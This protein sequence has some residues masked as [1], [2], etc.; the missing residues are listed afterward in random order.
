[1]R[2]ISIALITLALMVSF[3]PFQTVRKTHALVKA[4][5][6]FQ[7]VKVAEGVYAAIAK[8]GGLASGN[9]GF[10]AGDHGVLIVD[11]FFTPIAVEELIS[12]IG[13]LTPQPIRYA[14]NTHYHLDH[15]GGNQVLAARGV[16]I[17]AHD[18]VAKWQTTKNRR[19]LPAPE[20]LQ[21]RR[22]EVARQLA[23]TPADQPDKRAQFERQLRSIDARLTIKLTN[24]NVTFSSGTV[25]LYLG[26]R[27]FIL[28]TL[29]GHTGGDV[30]VYVPDA[31]VVFM[32]DMGWSKTL[33][34]LVDATVN[35]WI[36]SLDK[37]LAD[38]PTAKFIPGHGEVATAVEMRDFRDYLV[39]LRAR[40]KQGIADGLTIDQAK[41]QLIL[42]EKYKSFA[43]QNF[44]QPN[45]EDMYKE[46]KGTKQMN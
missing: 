22:A 21:K 36:T 23:E 44:A 35:D 43:F 24:P 19:F 7:L 9:A 3:A 28:F 41:Q 10:V 4:E 20:E 13:K 37:I 33:P 45:V 40:V 15:T 25:H 26:K 2:R 30:L 11:T 38:Y 5:D 16:P 6:D 17:I 27:D 14:V 29:P 18:N 31:N 42:P 32:G 12:E 8:P 34:N 39:D 1:M 46:L